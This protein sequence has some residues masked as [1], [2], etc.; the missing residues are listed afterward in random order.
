M[1]LTLSQNIRKLRK[2]RKMTQNE[3]AEAVSCDVKYLGDVEN[4]WF[5][6]SASASVEPMNSTGTSF[7]IAPSAIIAANCLADEDS[8]C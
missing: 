1:E 8:E 5:Y 3:F 6:P 4:G 2:E 7:L